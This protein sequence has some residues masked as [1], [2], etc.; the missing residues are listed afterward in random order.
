MG[1]RAVWIWWTTQLG[2]ATLFEFDE[3]LNWDAALFERSSCGEASSNKCTHF[4]LDELRLYPYLYHRPK[5]VFL[6]QRHR[7]LWRWTENSENNI[8]KIR[9]SWYSINRF[10]RRDEQVESA[11][12]KRASLI[13]KSSENR[14]E[15]SQEKNK[16]QNSVQSQS[17]DSNFQRVYLLPRGY[18]T[19]A[20]DRSREKFY[21]F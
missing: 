21:L 10:T 6:L 20:L 7:P 8:K 14:K 11:F 3:R 15:E 18:I 12:D 19:R 4:S 5:L 17:Y 16:K 13:H 9:K 2:Y 1:C